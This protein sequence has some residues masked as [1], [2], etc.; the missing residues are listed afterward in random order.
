MSL[1]SEI[2]K[3]ILQGAQKAITP[4]TKKVTPKLSSVLK[5]MTTP[6]RQS[7]A[8]VVK[9]TVSTVAP[10]L[11]N[12]ATNRPVINLGAVPE[13]SA[14]TKKLYE[15]VATRMNEKGI[16]TEGEKSQY[17][18]D[19][20][21]NVRRRA[22]EK[23][24]KESQEQVKLTPTKASKGTKKTKVTTAETPVVE[25]P[26]IKTPIIDENPLDALT[27]VKTPSKALNALKTLGYYG[28]AGT[29]AS[30]PYLQDQILPESD[31]ARKTADVV[32]VIGSALLGKRL[33]KSK[34]PKTVKI[35]GVIGSAYTG[36][37]QAG[38]FFAGSTPAPLDTLGTGEIDIAPIAPGNVVLDEAP[39]EEQI[40]TG[41][42]QQ[43]AVDALLNQAVDAQVKAITGG[44]TQAD[45]NA[46]T[47]QAMND[48][49]ANYGSAQNMTNSLA[50]GDQALAANLEYIRSQYEMGTNIINQ[51]YDTARQQI[52]GYQTQSSQ[53][54]ANTAAAQQAAISQAA[55]GL[56]TFSPGTMLTPEQ[57]NAAGLSDTALGGAGI[58]GSS[59]VN[60]LG[61]VA[62]A[63]NAAATL[64][65]GSS[66]NNQLATSALD[67]AATLSALQQ[68][69]LYQSSS[70][71][72][73][74]A[75]TK[76]QVAQQNAIYDKQNA[77]DLANKVYAT[78]IDAINNQANAKADLA[79]IAADAA[80]KKAT[81]LA[82]LSPEEYRSYTGISAKSNFKS[83]SWYGT[84]I[85]GDATALTKVSYKDSKGVTQK[86]TVSD[87]QNNL[88]LVYAVL[89]QPEAT[90]PN[91]ALA[92]WTVFYN[93]YAADPSFIPTLTARKMPT[94]A[95][96][97][98]KTLWPNTPK[99]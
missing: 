57:G 5:G 28:G 89:S 15:D 22:A 88:D 29:L 49:I 80:T 72:A 63:Q 47:Q 75:K 17:V 36:L 21:L 64:G 76:A 85:P 42:T 74:D 44:V 51:A 87:A 53:L 6:L 83:P 94:S 71:V 69:A 18:A 7:V 61:G 93:K 41:P 91:T 65:L 78:K 97:M 11:S 90:D 8:P 40:P 50:Q 60:A 45:L 98:V 33:L 34:L 52:Q 24:L 23:L 79:K 86:A 77:I 10:K 31:F 16:I 38:D 92:T 3:R 25:T 27:A 20:L 96:A 14:Y 99:K 1:Q 39:M 55:G 26:K 54:M 84:V 30:A 9:E 70:A 13:P 37:T 19:Q 58:T 73:T 82:N 46:Q 32:G 67:R 56:A 62:Q 68:D 66:L 12:I 35:P 95:S 81:I 2:A 48:L 59:L 43:Q 4:V